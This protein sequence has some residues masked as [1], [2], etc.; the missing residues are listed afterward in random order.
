MSI[1]MQ[2]LEN[3]KK[4]ASEVSEREGCQLYDLEMAGST[5]HRILRVYI[6]RFEKKS[7]DDD[8]APVGATI[9]DCANVSRGLSL[10]LDVEDVVPGGAYELEVSTPG[11]DR[12]LKEAWHFEKVL[13]KNIQIAATEGL[14]LPA[15]YVTKKKDIKSISGELKAASDSGIVV[16]SGEYDWSIP[17]ELIHKAKVKTIF[18]HQGAKKAHKQK[19]KR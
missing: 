15:G 3:I 16:S 7:D 10:L 17:L 19:K 2:Q 14:A 5:S 13:G 8:D 12:E 11:L 1:S 4:L 6:D 18:E 9:D